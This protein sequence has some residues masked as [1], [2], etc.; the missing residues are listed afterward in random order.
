MRREIIS[1]H[2]VRFGEFFEILCVEV[3]KFANIYPNA[4]NM[5]YKIFC[6]CSQSLSN[7]G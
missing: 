3:L 6:Y 7:S 5:I 4:H 1:L 2:L